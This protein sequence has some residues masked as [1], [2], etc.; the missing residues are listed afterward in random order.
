MHLIKVKT[1][2]VYFPQVYPPL[3]F[4]GGSIWTPP[5][6]HLGALV[7]T[8]KHSNAMVLI[9]GSSLNL[10]VVCPTWTFCAI[11]FISI[12][13]SVTHPDQNPSICEYAYF[14]TC[15]LQQQVQF[16]CIWLLSGSITKPMHNKGVPT[17]L[18]TL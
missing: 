9:L 17:A 2:L 3:Q 11:T 18:M 14:S 6:S 10:I 13:H 8:S 12:I 1:R 16:N 5:W 4:T 15:W 7:A